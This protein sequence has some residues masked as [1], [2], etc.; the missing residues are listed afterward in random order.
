MLSPT[1]VVNDQIVIEYSQFQLQ[2]M[3][4]FHP[5]GALE[6]DDT[7]LWRMVAGRGGARFHSDSNDRQ[8][9]VRL[10]SWEAAPEQVVA[11]WRTVAEGVIE[12]DSVEVGLWRVTGG[13]TGQHLTLTKAAPHHIR[14]SLRSATDTENE[15]DNEAD[16]REWWLL[17]LWPVV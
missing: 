1:S 15:D 8:V 10:E 13:G 7:S 16:V 12:P 14:A 3:A 11:P 5:A 4:R 2:D 9:P 17:Q 6:V